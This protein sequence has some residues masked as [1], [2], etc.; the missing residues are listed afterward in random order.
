VVKSWHGRVGRETERFERSGNGQS[1]R[2]DDAGTDGKGDEERDEL[3]GHA[4]P[5]E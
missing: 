5:V 4:G 3:S 1:N 2:A